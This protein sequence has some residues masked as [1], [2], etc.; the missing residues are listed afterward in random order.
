M[1]SV[2]RVELLDDH[3][4]HGAVPSAS[5]PTPG[6]RRPASARLLSP[7][8]HSPVLGQL[9]RAV[10]LRAASLGAVVDY[11][12]F[13]PSAR[14]PASA[15]SLRGRRSGRGRFRGRSR[16]VFSR[17]D[18]SPSRAPRPT[19]LLGATATAQSNS[20]AS[21]RGL[22]HLDRHGLV[23]RW[24]RLAQPPRPRRRH[25]YGSLCAPSLLAR[26]H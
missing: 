5:S 21:S 6:R 15:P 26:R 4:G 16:V 10:S 12:S 11:S 18:F 24:R 23:L 8:G 1:P 19:T 3:R 9:H 13:R 25:R 17:F 20:T 2:A 22:P 14:C 7:R